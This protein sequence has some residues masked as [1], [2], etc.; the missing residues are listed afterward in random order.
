MLFR[1]DYNDTVNYIKFN[2]Y[3]RTFSISI[4]QEE[5]FKQ[6]LILT[7]DA[8]KE[9]LDKTGKITLEGIS[10][11]FNKATLKPKSKKAILSTVALMERY[12]DLI[13]TV[14]GYTDNK[15]SDIYNNRLSKERA[16]SVRN[17]IIAE[18]IES[19]R[20]QSNGY[21][22]ENPVATND[23]EEG[24]AKNRRVELHKVSG[25]DKK[26][27]ITIDFIKP[28]EN[29]VIVSRYAYKNQELSIHHTKPYSKKKKL[30]NYKGYLDTINY[31]ILKDGKVNKSISRKE[32][33]KNYENILELYNAKIIGKY[34]NTLFFKIADRGDKVTVYGRIDAYDGKYNINFLIEK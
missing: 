3:N 11:D 33:I 26:S 34:I 13:L 5:S 27:L 21:G 28:L 15:G 9:E 7:P 16:A 18:G 31:Q 1:L 32:I 30:V 8:I 23:T 19:S 4:L 14:N 17:A 20:L 24:R 12:K 10:F 2:S 6:S 22:E 25:G 29:S